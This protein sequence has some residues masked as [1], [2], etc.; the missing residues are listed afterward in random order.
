MPKT[1]KSMQRISSRRLVLFLGLVYTVLC[2][3]EP[4]RAGS[5]P[6]DVVGKVTVGYQGWF[7]C[8][9]DGAP[10]GGWW[11]YSGGAAP[12]PN[13]L[14]NSIHCWPDMRQF[15]KVYQTGF[16]NFGN[17]QPATLFSSYDQQTVDTHFRWMAENGID[18]AALQRF[19]PTGGEGPTRDVM[20]T[21]VRKA[22]ETYGRKFYIM[23]DVS[24]WTTMQTEIKAD[25]TNKMSA[26]TLSPAYARQNGK[27]VVCIWGF[28]F[29]DG[30][31]PI[32]AITCNEVIN[33][34]KGQGCYLIGG[35][36]THW[37]TEN[38]DSTT[39]FLSAYA[40][41]NMI[42]PW[43][44]GRIG[45]TNDVDNFYNNVNLPDQAYCNANG[46]DYQPCVLPGDTGQRAHGNF[47][48]RQFYNMQRA[49][50]QG[51]Y[52]SMFDEFNEG[53][54]IA[55]TAENASMSPI[56]TSAL[57][58]TLDQDGTPCS[59]DYYLRLTGDAGRMFKGQIALTATRPTLPMFPVT[60]PSAPT[61]LTANGGNAQ[62]TLSWTA[63]PG[64][65]SYNIKRAIVSGGTYTTIAT[66]VGSIGY[67][68]T[69]LVNGTTYYY[70]ISM[71]NS[72]GE[73]PDSAQV[74]A[75]PAAFYLVN[76]A[77]S[78][79]NPFTA[80]ANFSG[81]LTSSTS[82]A[83]DTSGVTNPAPQPVYQTERYGNITYTFTN[84]VVGTSYKVRLHF[85]EI[86]YNAVNVRR[87]NVFINGTQKLTNYDIF[88]DA[89]AKNKATI[90]EFTVA[91]N[92]SGQIIIQYANGASDNA[93][94]SGIE[95]LPLNAPPLLAPTDLAATAVSS[96]EVSLS[97]TAP[98]SATG[99]N[100]K[101]ATVDGGP[102]TN[103]ATGIAATGYW[104]T[105]L[106]PNTACYYVVSAVNTGGQS[107]NSLQASATT[108][109][110]PPPNI[111]T[112][113]AAM[114]GNGEVILNWTPAAG[115]TSYNVKRATVS[116][117]PYATIA[118]PGT[119][120][121]TNT[122]LVNNTTYY[123]VV[124]ATNAV[125]ASTNSMEVS[126]LPSVGIASANSENPPNETAAKAF[127]GSVDTKWL[128]SGNTGWLQYYFR[129]IA[130]TVVRYDLSSANDVPGRDPRDWQFQG[131]HDGTNWITLD[132]RTG[133]IFTA[134]KQT[135]PYP[136]SNNTGYEYWRLNITANNGD[137][138]NVQLS[139]M[140]FTFFVGVPPAAPTGLTTTA[141]DS[142]AVL[143]WAAASGATGYNLKRSTISNGAYAVI[144][145]NLAALA[146]TNTGLV[147]GTIYYF[148]VSA[149]N[150]AG[151]S[152]NSV[153]VSARPVSPT[154]PL[155]NLG[156][157]SGLL[158]FVWPVDHTGWRLQA[159]TNAPGLG[160]STNWSTVSGS[161]ATNQIFIPAGTSN[162]SVFFRLVYP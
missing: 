16:T 8:A 142:Q 9:G 39:N 37:R 94:S 87:F 158:Q 18:T 15:S 24:G 32:D 114:S 12:T 55:C 6:G 5:L 132:T 70:V 133:E 21:K 160:L 76:S 56:G 72:L 103:I 13:G 79:A 157:S 98:A 156:R 65:T 143:N 155:L 19:N 127:D 83:I 112:G 109:T 23:Y 86:F 111:P 141:G 89:G 26:L 81:G 125:G 101:R 25:W 140:A 122:G 145:T 93:K 58:F 118:S 38:S 48:W 107:T 113:L 161:A 134:R 52:I 100:V 105:G 130:K 148:V 53:N 20:A 14:T 28:G 116:G 17:G 22:A 74:S 4:A 129:G 57:Y 3:A 78:G 150:S 69:G 128:T 123:Y 121:Y 120:T 80:D 10:I 144:A 31:H 154:A 7:S 138:N 11:H 85:A 47:M 27:P 119:T 115:A 95:V 153:Q 131:S 29:S 106:P 45:N 137:A 110:P 46:I 71:V 49:G 60:S 77:G 42:S 152:A 1:V 43:M 149:T 108:Q 92:G 162:G 96:S 2:L 41:F 33:W 104:D 30:N 124:S 34:F 59:S 136:I 159:Q 35:V 51:I 73:S 82:S 62:V 126:S 90:K 135:R 147:N 36:P 64:A 54:Q 66:N 99:Y 117:G 61:G 139:E 102:Y 63:S 50:C 91:A 75:T 44:V 67:S 40:A 146:Y 88:A 97:W 84:L 151:E 68:D